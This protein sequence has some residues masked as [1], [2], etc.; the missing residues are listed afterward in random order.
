MIYTSYYANM[1]NLPKDIRCIAIS[2]IVPKGIYIP[3]YEKLEPPRELL[4]VWKTS[5]ISWYDYVIYYKD[6]V[7]SKLSPNQVV[8]DLYDLVGM[9]CTQQTDIALLCYEKDLLCHRRIVAQWFMESGIPCKE[10]DESEERR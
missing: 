5:S 10:F 2:R 7:L 1:K 6:E 4:H 9:N 3:Q 8:K